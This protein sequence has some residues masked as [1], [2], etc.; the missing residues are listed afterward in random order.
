VVFAFQAFGWNSKNNVAI[1]WVSEN[2]QQSL[3][4][5]KASPFF[6]LF[7]RFAGTQKTMLPYFG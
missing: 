2:T 7:K 3:W 6:L 1:F 4:H 5:P